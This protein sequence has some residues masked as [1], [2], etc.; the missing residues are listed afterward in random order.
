MRQ[1]IKNK[2]LEK[3]IKV[4]KTTGKRKHKEYGTSKL[5]ERFAKNFLDKLGVEY[6]YQYQAEDIGRYYDFMLKTK[7]GSKVLLEIDGDYFHS[8]GLT[9]EE[10]NP[11]Q[12]HNEYV[13]KL[14]DEWAL[15]HGIPILRIWE[16]DINDNPSKV[17]KELK[18][19]IGESDKKTLLKENKKKRH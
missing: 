3:H 17:M 7:M 5:E 19:L 11:M 18:K 12:K 6:V 9:H 13:D 10:K 8:Y 1:P 2:T 16:H 15:I 4:K 14:K